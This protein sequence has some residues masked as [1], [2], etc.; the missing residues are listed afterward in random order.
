METC[1]QCKTSEAKTQPIVCVMQKSQVD[2]QDLKS[3][4]AKG[5][6]ADDKEWL[7]MPVCANCHQHPKLKGHFF[8]RGQA[9]IALRNAGSSDLG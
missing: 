1:Y 8:M 4:I 7:A 3:A 5:I 2:P 6:G 9:K